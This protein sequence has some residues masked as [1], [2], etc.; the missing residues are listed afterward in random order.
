MSLGVVRPCLSSLF[1][2]PHWWYTDSLLPLS[3]RV[4]TIH[5][6]HQNWNTQYLPNYDLNEPSLFKVSRLKYFAVV[7]QSSVEQSSYNQNHAIVTIWIPLVLSTQHEQEIFHLYNAVVG[8]VVRHNWNQEK[9]TCKT[10]QY[11]SLP[12]MYFTSV[13]KTRDSVNR[14]QHA[15]HSSYESHT[16]AQWCAPSS[17]K[18]NLF[19]LI[20][21]SVIPQ[22]SQEQPARC[23]PYLS[24]PHLPD[25]GG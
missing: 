9:R 6:S 11:L 12:A 7:T 17:F 19:W 8:T 5:C 25:G 10:F 2:C 1:L 23:L 18:P 22:I 24:S 15:T 4:T 20:L 16:L 3:Q 13:Y 14:Q 21:H